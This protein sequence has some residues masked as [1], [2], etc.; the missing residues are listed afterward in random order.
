M[1]LHPGN[2]PGAARALLPA[3]PNEVSR[4][5]NDGLVGLRVPQ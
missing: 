5:A 2:L 1:I 3:L 4:V